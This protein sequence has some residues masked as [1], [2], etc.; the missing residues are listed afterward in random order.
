MASR[1]LSCL[2]LVWMAKSRRVSEQVQ[3]ALALDANETEFGACNYVA[4]KDVPAEQCYHAPTEC[5]KLT[6]PDWKADR[7]DADGK[8]ML[9]YAYGPEFNQKQIGAWKYDPGAQVIKF[10]W[11][12]S[13]CMG[14]TS[15]ECTGPEAKT[16]SNIPGKLAQ[17]KLNPSANMWGSLTTK[18]QIGEEVS[19]PF[20]EMPLAE[21]NGNYHLQFGE[22]YLDHVYACSRS[23]YVVKY[24][25]SQGALCDD[26]GNSP[27][28][29][30][31]GGGGG[32]NCP[33][34]KCQVTLKNAGDEGDMMQTIHMYVYPLYLATVIL[35][36]V[37]CYR[38]CGF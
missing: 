14:E 31:G 37:A 36:T 7:G 18:F 20:G 17:S 26:Q 2:L 35:A 5:E 11:S 15:T 38:R 13:Y 8:L 27:N 28:P 9:F 34:C 10:W 25:D 1:Y 16:K 21:D 12:K 23:S 24:K 29:G 32:G 6:D 30:G 3:V 33:P 19:T 4:P 22:C